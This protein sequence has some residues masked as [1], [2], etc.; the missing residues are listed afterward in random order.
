MVIGASNLDRNDVVVSC[1]A[2]QI[3]SDA[4]FDGLSIPKLAVLG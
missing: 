3:F 1:D 4:F 2:T